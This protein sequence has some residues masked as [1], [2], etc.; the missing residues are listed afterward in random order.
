MNYYERFVGDFQRDTGHLS[1]TEI[2][3]YDRL[4]DHYYATEIPL[5][6]DYTDLCRISRAMDKIE[7]KAVR[8]VADEF[9]P[10]AEDG[11]RHNARADKE[12]AKAAN[13]IKSAKENGKKGGRPPKDKPEPSESANP[14]ETHQKPTRFQSANPPETHSG[15]H[16]MPCT[17][18]NQ[19]PLASGVPTSTV[20][21]PE[22]ENPLAPES[23][24]LSPVA[25][26][27]RGLKA[28]G[29]GDT[30]PHD[31][32]LLSLLGAGLTP[33][34]ILAAGQDGKGKAKGFRWV[35]ATAEGRRRDADNVKPLPAAKAS[36]HTG[37]EKID[38]RAG[39]GEDGRF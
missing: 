2:G 21:A 23:G 22:N 6:K 29:Y 27:C 24:D 9:F 5:P 28:M 12:I 11:M 30:S 39:I 14:P 19:N 1:C 36:R 38:Y 32:K 18:V 3:V 33:D 35:L 20:V 8:R 26:V 7:Q 16:H 4:L 13:R 37:F 25:R 31:A 17:T 15:V 34:E 10:V